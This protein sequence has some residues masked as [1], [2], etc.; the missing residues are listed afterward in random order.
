MF[1]YSKMDI[2]NRHDRGPL[3]FFYW[4]PSE[5]LV[6]ERDKNTE[7]EENDMNIDKIAYKQE[8]AEAQH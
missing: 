3:A 5:D 8:L 7:Q 6:R 4:R 2:N 1:N